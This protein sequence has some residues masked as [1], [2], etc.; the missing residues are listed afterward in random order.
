MKL[1]QTK[2]KKIPVCVTVD[3]DP[4]DEIERSVDITLKLFKELGVSATFFAA[5]EYVN[6]K[7]VRKIL[8]SGHE[9]G[10][11]GLKH[12]DFENFDKLGYLD[13]KRIIS[14]ATTKLRGYV[15]SKNVLKDHKKNLCNS[16]LIG[17]RGPRVK[18]NKHTVRVLKELG[19][20]YDSSVCS[21]RMD[22]FSSNLINLG[23]LFAPRRP[24][25]MGSSSPFKKGKSGIIEFPVSAFVLP[26]ISTTMRLFGCGF[27]KVFLWFLALESKISKKPIV[28]LMHTK[29]FTCKKIPFNWDMIIPS[30][31]WITHGF[32]LRFWLISSSN[33]KN[34]KDNRN[35]IKYMGKLGSF[36][37][38]SS[39]SKNSE[40]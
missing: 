31:K 5:A 23:W 34:I 26:F 36:R 19:Y 32:P 18:I 3:I 16:K 13:Q 39:L 2:S 22:V 33:P 37:L 17:F 30:R 8:D 38:V 4:D 11:H 40:Q 1:S 12:D 20:K 27:M 25:M 35:L 28:Y 15:E 6:Q 9:V 29:D 14:D 21:Q 10:C 7:I 24:Y